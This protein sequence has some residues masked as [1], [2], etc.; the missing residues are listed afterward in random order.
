MSF[1]EKGC[2][3]SDELQRL[4]TTADQHGPSGPVQDAGHLPAAVGHVGRR[5]LSAPSGNLQTSKVTYKAVPV[6]IYGPGNLGRTGIY[7]NTNLN[8]SQTFRLPH[9]MRVT[10]QFNI[11]NLFDQDFTTRSFTAPWRDALIMPNDGGHAHA[12]GRSSPAST[13]P[14]S[15]RHGS[16]RAAA[17]LG[18]PDP[19][20]GMDSGYRGA[21]S[22]RFYVRLQF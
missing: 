20:Y 12:P 6:M 22:A 18:R 9:G 19:R 4:G 13:R 21:R 7:T 3:D 14:R 8:F 2:P 16:P 15:R 1:T 10:A 5:R 17:R 11:T